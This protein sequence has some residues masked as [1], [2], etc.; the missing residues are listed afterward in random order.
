MVIQQGSVIARDMINADE[1]N[2]TTFGTSKI[3]LNTKAS[4]IHI[5]M[6]GNSTG[7]L[8]LQADSLNLVLK[9]KI[10]LNIYGIIGK[11]NLEMYNNAFAISE[12]TADSLNIK[13]FGNSDFRAEK[14]ETG[15]ISAELEETTKARLYAYKSIELSSRG[16][17]KTYLW[18]NP[19]I[20]IHEFLNSSELYKREE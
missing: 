19:Q 4:F 8:N 5:H 1:L 3:E 15:V 17:A 12:G 14:M 16:S 13:L 11:G 7:N 2:I 10:D 20:I 18:G 9:D 6:E